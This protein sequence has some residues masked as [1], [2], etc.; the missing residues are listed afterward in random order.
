[1][2]PWEGNIWCP[3]CHNVYGLVD[4]IMDISGIA[5]PYIHFYN[6]QHTCILSSS[7]VCTWWWIVMVSTQKESIQH[8]NSLACSR[9]LYTNT[10]FLYNLN[11]QLYDS[12]RPNCLPLM[13]SL[14]RGLDSIA[15]SIFEVILVDFDK[16]WD[17]HWACLSGRDL[18]VMSFLDY[19]AV[20]NLF[21]DSVWQLICTS[22][23]YQAKLP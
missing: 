23:L 8:Y 12:I 13:T 6:M 9:L 1:M 17:E 15:V 5:M 11:A 16:Y 18:K 19:L 4:P 10:L 22:S 20:L 2:V 14:L 7:K 21:G 3:T